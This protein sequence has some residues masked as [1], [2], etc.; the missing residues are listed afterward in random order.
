MIE[1]LVDR[2]PCLAWALTEE[3]LAE[4]RSSKT[5]ALAERRP[6]CNGSRPGGSRLRGHHGLGGYCL[7]GSF[8]ARGPHPERAAAL[9]GVPAGPGPSPRH[10][11]AGPGPT[12]APPMTGGSA[13]GPCPGR[14]GGAAGQEGR[15][16]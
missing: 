16:Q 12:A 11:P 3:L 13:A 4:E 10:A 6:C 7:R 5:Q 1:L 2:K 9:R 15:G 8:R 14:S